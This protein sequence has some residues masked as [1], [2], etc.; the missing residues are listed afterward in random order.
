MEEAAPSSGEALGV[1]RRAEGQHAGL[2]LHLC[3]ASEMKQGLLLGEQ[4]CVHA[5]S[6]RHITG[7]KEMEQ[8]S[9]LQVPMRIYFQ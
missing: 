7:L 9:S 1:A 3:A 2:G 4:R 5:S 6:S 8:L